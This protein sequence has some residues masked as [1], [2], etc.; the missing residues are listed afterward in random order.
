MANL[1]FETT[2]FSR[3]DVFV[4]TKRLAFDVQ[5]GERVLFVS[6][7]SDSQLCVGVSIGV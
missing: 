1:N 7:V 6:Y 4:S 3:V 2:I 5:I